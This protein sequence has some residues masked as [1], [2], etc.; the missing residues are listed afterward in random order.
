MKTFRYLAPLLGGVCFAVLQILPAAAQIETT[1]EQAILVDYDSGEVMYCK[2][3]RTP[4][5]PSSMSKLM[6]VEMVFQRLKDGRLKLEDTFHV[7]ETAWR[8]GL[9]ENESKMWVAVNSTMG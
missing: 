3:C 4:M 7:S 1:A 9:K 5:P 2:N 6:T 8:Q